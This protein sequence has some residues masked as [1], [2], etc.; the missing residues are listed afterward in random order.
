MTPRQTH[1]EWYHYYCSNLYVFNGPFMIPLSAFGLKYMSTL[2]KVG[3][4]DA[5]IVPQ[6]TSFD[7]SVSSTYTHT[8]VVRD[9]AAHV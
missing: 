2:G 4:V 6:K 9:L 5:K 7:L 8:G 3:A 1:N